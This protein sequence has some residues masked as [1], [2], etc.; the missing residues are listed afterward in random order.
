[1]EPRAKFPTALCRKL[2][3]NP[4]RVEVWGDGTQVR[5][6]LYIDDALERIQQV[7]DANHYEGPV[8]VGSDEQVTVRE[9][10]EW[11]AETADASPEWVWTDGP[12]GV[13]H[14]AAD[15][16]E[17]DRRYGTGPLVCARDG[18][19]RT[20]TWLRSELNERT[21]CPVTK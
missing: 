13:A 18:F 4:R 7:I 1:M 5:T 21:P 2:I 10:C 19:A 3:D 6:F 20:Y 11:T 16:S 14:R 17:W 9:C 15:N 12:T 8:N